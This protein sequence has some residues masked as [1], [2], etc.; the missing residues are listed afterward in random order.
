[1]RYL[2]IIILFFIGSALL[3]GQETINVKNDTLPD[4]FYL[5][6][7]VERGGEILPEIELDEISVVSKM[8]VKARFKWWRHKR[9]VYNVKKVYPYAVLIRESIG[10]VSDTLM[11]IEGDRERRKFLKE[12]EKSI[13]KE[14]EDDMRQMTITQGR[15]LIKLVDR[16]TQN[17]GFEL[18]QEYR[19]PVSAVFWQGISRLFGTNLKVKYDGEG[20]DYLIEKVVYEIETGRI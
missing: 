11:L 15:I 16:E 4:R 12:Y 2:S 20:K 18:I 17:S 19:G 8:G 5:L 10:D 13:F 1:M 14:Y 7:N 6:E 3:S 9:L